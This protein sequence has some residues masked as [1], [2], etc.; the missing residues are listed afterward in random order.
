MEL[1][2]CFKRMKEVPDIFT[3][4]PQQVQN[5]R[6][7]FKSN[8]NCTYI[9]EDFVMFMSIIDGL[10]LDTINI[11][12]IIENDK[13]HSVLTFEKNSNDEITANFMDRLDVSI[14]SHLFIFATDSKGGKY[15]FKKDKEDNQIYYIP[16]NRDINVIIFENFTQVLEESIEKELNK[17]V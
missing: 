5:V 10:K 17:Y 4:I 12:S 7:Y 6:E 1:E 16:T 14:S 8:F 15:T 11:F 13:P 9:P 2:N 3:L